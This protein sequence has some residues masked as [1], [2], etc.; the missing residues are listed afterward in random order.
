MYTSVALTCIRKIGALDI[1]HI[2]AY[3]MGHYIPQISVL[4]QKLRFEAVRHTHHVGI[5]KYL[6][7]SAISCSYAYRHATDTLRNLRC[8]RGGHLPRRREAGRVRLW[9][10][11]LGD[12]RVFRHGDRSGRDAG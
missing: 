8:E 3:G 9:L 1:E 6:T 4:T 2:L 5:D 12:R 7:V 11:G 10:S